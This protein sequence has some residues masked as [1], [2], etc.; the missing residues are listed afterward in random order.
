MA[1]PSFFKRKERK[2]A[3]ASSPDLTGD[4]GPVQAARVRARRRLIGAVVLL[5]VGVVGFPLLFE[6]KPRPLPGNIPI[7]VAR[8]DGSS[9][10][11]AAATGLP[12]PS[13]ALT[14][15][16][17]EPAEPAARTAPAPTP[18]VAPSG[19]TQAGTAAAQ[20]ASAPAAVSEPSAT[21]VAKTDARPASAAPAASKPATDT[22]AAEDRK[23][24]EA[25]KQADEKK[26]ADERKAADEKKQA[27]ARKLAEDKK[28]ADARKLA[29]AK[30]DAKADAERARQALEGRA[31]SAP[32][33]TVDGKAS[34]AKAGRYVV[35][36]GAFTD[37]NTLREVRAKVEKLG[38]K[39]YT[40]SVDTDSGKRT[41]VRV[42]PFAT[43]QEAESA[44]GKLKGAGLPGN[45]LVL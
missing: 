2:P 40:Q 5:A 45:V 1:L 21:P 31:A 16:P 10:G 7:D 29:E 43:K 35:Q 34:D 33:A 30:A 23:L 13:P 24:A 22:K 4:D 32:L 44:S 11:P 37:A 36:V 17:P 38:L 41:R 26:A 8:R 14:E 15:L 9:P 19:P 28:Q 18:A 42:G 3:P 20:P 27:E 12:R 39:T 25:R 6:T